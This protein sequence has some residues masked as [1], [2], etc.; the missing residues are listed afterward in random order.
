MRGSELSTRGGDLVR[1]WLEGSPLANLLGMEVRRLG[2]DEAEVVL[3]FRNEVVT[4]ADVVHGGAIAALLDTAATAA[5]WSSDEVPET[6]R[7][8][9]VGLT[10]SYV[11]AA[12][13][14]D[15]TAVARV[16]RRGGSLCFVDAE[17]TTGDGRVVARALVTYKL[18]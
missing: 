4:V 2:P 17:A 16:I 5:A 14:Q 11:A 1:I 12:R 13:G 7:G 8:A 15:V 18:G 10:V 9:T 3:P 6:L